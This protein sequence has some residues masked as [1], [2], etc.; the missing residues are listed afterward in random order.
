MV[1]RTRMGRL[2][3][4][5]SND[6]GESWT[7]P[8][9]M[10]LAASDAPAQVRTLPNRHLLIV[11]NQE[12][13]DEIK[14]GHN[15]TRL[16]CAVSRNGGSIWE[17]FQNVESMHESTRVEPG[18]VRWIGQAEVYLKPGVPAPL[19]EKEFIQS[20]A[21]H[22]RWCYPSVFVGKDRV[23]IAHTYSTYEPHPERAELVL[24]RDKAG[25]FNQKLKVLPLTWFYGGK[26][27]SDNPLLPKSQQPAKP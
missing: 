21:A 19:R 15:R 27:P 9:P 14:L 4:A 13:P 17:F 3:Q 11:W 24:S 26:Q 25:A 10:A 5:W 18:P 8:Q 2:F 12:S 23:F 20:A 22:G 7:R 1:M 6:N 16:S